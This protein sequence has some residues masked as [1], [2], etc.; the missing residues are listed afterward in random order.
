MC[1][2]A[3]LV[4]AQNVMTTYH[5]KQLEDLKSGLL[6]AVV[7]NELD[8]LVKQSAL[9]IQSSESEAF[10]NAL[11]YNYSYSRVALCAKNDLGLLKTNPSSVNLVDLDGNTIDMSTYP[12]RNC[13]IMEVVYG[14]LSPQLDYQVFKKGNLKRTDEADKFQTLIENYDLEYDRYRSYIQQLLND[15]GYWLQKDFYTSAEFIALSDWERQQLRMD[16]KNPLSKGGRVYSPPSEYDFVNE[17]MYGRSRFNSL[18]IQRMFPAKKNI[19]RKTYVYNNTYSV[20]LN[21]QLE[22]DKRYSSSMILFSELLENQYTD[23]HR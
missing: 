18:V 9:R 7:P 21:F 20:L 12:K 4:S 17:A 3:V 14:F 1:F 15:D 6:I 8:E 22:S 2:S 19:G 13:F 11:K 16:L 5:K 23:L 10:I